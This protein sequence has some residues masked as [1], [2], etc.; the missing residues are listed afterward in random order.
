MGGPGV[1][2]LKLREVTREFL[3][4]LKG[5]WIPPTIRCESVMETIEATQVFDVEMGS[6]V[7]L[8]LAGGEQ[9]KGQRNATPAAEF[10]LAAIQTVIQ[11]EMTRLLHRINEDR[12]KAAD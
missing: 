11:A 2:L 7:T 4:D 12:W 6:E 5:C 3:V 9:V 1:G 8:Q 10:D